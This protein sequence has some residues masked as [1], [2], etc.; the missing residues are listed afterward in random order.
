MEDLIE[1]VPIKRL[2]RAEEVAPV[3]LF[4]CSD[5]ASFIIGQVTLIHAGYT[6]Q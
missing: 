5:G 6:I 4:L 1:V 3:V 2:G